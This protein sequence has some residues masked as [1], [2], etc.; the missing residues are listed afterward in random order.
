MKKFFFGLW[1]TFLSVSLV[2][3]AIIT[4][5]NQSVEYIRLLARNASL[6]LDSV[7]YNPA[8]TA[9]LANGFHLALHNQTIKQEKTVINAFPFLNSSEYVGQV[10]V[11]I[12]PSFFAVYKQDKWAVSFGFGPN[13]G[14][15]TAEFSTGLPSFE[16]PLSLLPAS[17]AMM[18]VPTTKYAADMYFKGQSAFYG[19]QGNVSYAFSEMFSLA[20]GLRYIYAVNKYQGHLENI[21]INPLH[22]LLNPSGQMMSAAQ[23]FTLAGMPEM[24]AEV[25]DQAVDVT[26]KGTGF[27]PLVG[28][29]IR[30]SERL[31]IGIRYEFNTKVELEN[32]SKVDDTGLYPD[33][34]KFRND[35]PAI[36][37]LGVEYALTEP[38][39][40]MVSYTY[41]FDKNA[42]WEGRENLVDSNTYDLGVGLEFD[43]TKR[44]TLSCGYLRSESGVSEE[45]Q[46]DFSYEL[47]SNSFGVGARI[48]LSP[49]I[50]LEL[51]GLY[52]KYI[53]DDKTMS[54]EEFP[55]PFSE[56]YQQWNWVFSVGLE[57][58]VK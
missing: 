31:N 42:N 46:T 19:F 54:I 51:G 20:V 35:I 56:S 52:S 22:P 49:S 11:P 44:I 24:A 17:M 18:G 28:L 33:G 6:R 27:T 38:F 40:I 34:Y 26:Q 47:D 29:D 36:L 10:Q 5:T 37:S 12:F 58:K 23:F 39:R 45:Y 3:G 14:G 43:L 50:D 25:S 7:Y 32:E 55:L 30:P 48:N 57:I 53:E 16:I 4:N 1:L 9:F 2:S 21:K 41:F 13:S 8:G 15:G